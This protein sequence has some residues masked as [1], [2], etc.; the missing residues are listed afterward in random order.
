MKIAAAATATAALH[1]LSHMWVAWVAVRRISSTD[2]C[3]S[4]HAQIGA[5]ILYSRSS[6]Q[7]LVQTIGFLSA[8]AADVCGG[9]TA[10]VTSSCPIFCY[11]F[12]LA[13]FGSAI[14]ST[15]CKHVDCACC[16]FPSFHH[17]RHHHHLLPL[18]LLRRRLL[19]PMRPSDGTAARSRRPHQLRRLGLKSL[20]WARKTSTEMCFS[21]A[22]TRGRFS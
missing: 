8:P 11:P 9:S 2:Q 19:R 17:R 12:A 21:S 20:A 16:S 18:L 14:G 13:L 15:N 4:A 10:T 5:D 22:G 7:P 6:Y 1:S 3:S